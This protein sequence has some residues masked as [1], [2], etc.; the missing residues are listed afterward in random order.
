MDVTFLRHPS[1]VRMHLEIVL[2]V[3]FTF[4]YTL[5][6]ISITIDRLFYIVLGIK[7][8]V[9]WNRKRTNLL[10]ILIWTLGVISTIAISLTFH[11]QRSNNKFAENFFQYFYMLMDIS[12]LLVC[13]VSYTTM[14]RLFKRTRHS[15]ATTNQA[16]RARSSSLEIFMNSRF[17]FSALLV[18]NF[19]LLVVIP[20]FVLLVHHL[21]SMEEG[22]VLNNVVWTLFLASHVS[23][24]LLYMFTQ[25]D[26]KRVLRRKIFTFS[27][28][29]VEFLRGRRRTYRSPVQKD[30]SLSFL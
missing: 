13:V 10:L 21:L 11:A 15:P 18:V 20:D 28:F 5:N 12:F 27:R 30:N 3:F 6:Y 24:A 4:M 7:Y 26:V 8:S 9:Y 16:T 22:V 23:D 2:Y 1:K 29:S 14:F 25:P 17:I 19:F